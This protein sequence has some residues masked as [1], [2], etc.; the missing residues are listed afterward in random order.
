MDGSKNGLSHLTLNEKLA[1][2][3]SLEKA[4]ASRWAPAHQKH[5]NVERH[6]DCA[7]TPDGVYSHISDSF[8]TRSKLGVK[9]RV[10]SRIRESD[11]RACPGAAWI[12]FL[13][14][15]RRLSG[16]SRALGVP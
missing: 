4:L 12:G 9:D 3:R 16:R 1:L 14:A 7:E 10:R 15:Q 5:Y 13:T 11:G 6:S 2:D 8:L